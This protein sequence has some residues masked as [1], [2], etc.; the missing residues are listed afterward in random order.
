MEGKKIK[1]KTLDSFPVQD[2]IKGSI[3]FLIKIVFFQEAKS[4][5]KTQLS[6]VWLDREEV[7]FS[8]GQKKVK[9]PK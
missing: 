8:T 4:L 2:D 5:R 3:W 9:R 6:L 1:R 7:P